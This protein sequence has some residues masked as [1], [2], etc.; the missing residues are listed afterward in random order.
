[1]N[2]VPIATFV[3]FSWRGFWRFFQWSL[4]FLFVWPMWLVTLALATNLGAALV[5]TWPFCHERWKNGYWLVFLTLLFIPIRIA[6]AVVGAV[7]PNMVP[8]PKPSALAAWANNGLDVAFLL[9]GIYWIYRM[10][11]LRWFAVAV[12]LMQLWLLSGAAFIAAM[13]LSGDWL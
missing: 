6:I 4:E 8:R 9:L 1:M 2:A 3:S 13:A 10:K 5:R 11:G 12:M 7:D